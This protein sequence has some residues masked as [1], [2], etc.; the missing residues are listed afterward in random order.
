MMA[1]RAALLAALLGCAAGCASHNSIADGTATAVRPVRDLPA[2]PMDG[3][4]ADYS[5][6]VIGPLDT[7]DVTVFQVPDLTRTVQAD[8]SGRITLPLVG[9]VEVRGKT[10][11]QID[12][13]LTTK[14]A[15]YLQTPDV[16][17]TLREA[18]SQRVTVEGA[19]AQP[20]VYP[21]TTRMSLLQMIATAK[22]LDKNADTELVA[23]FRQIDGQKMAAVF[24]VHAIRD[25]QAT[26]PA[27]YGNDVIVVESSGSKS[28]LRNALSVVPLAAL[29]RPFLF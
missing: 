11:E 21:I 26:D 16:T 6:Y 27:I 13:D 8:A 29:F 15:R 28:A 17:V 5:D 19:V 4:M 20:G 2:P 3:R 14:L 7:L 23:V 10:T 25:G 18:T 12:R 22:G 24:N 1:L 9:G